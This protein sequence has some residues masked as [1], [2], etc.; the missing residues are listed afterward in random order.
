MRS[1][2][3]HG[4]RRAVAHPGSA[5]QKGAL[6]RLEEVMCSYYLILSLTPRS[7]CLRVGSAEESPLSEQEISLEI[8]TP[9]S[10]RYQGTV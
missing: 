1:L 9:D 10:M 5:R 3:A 6:N 8:V 7:D 2:G 4:E